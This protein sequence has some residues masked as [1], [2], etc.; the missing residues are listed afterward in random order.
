MNALGPTCRR[1]LCALALTVL[2]AAHTVHAAD[3]SEPGLPAAPPEAVGVDSA[4]L[5][6]LSEWI[7]KDRLDVR[8]L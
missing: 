3:A 7:R 2:A 5:V 4:P 1:T 6:R 8:S